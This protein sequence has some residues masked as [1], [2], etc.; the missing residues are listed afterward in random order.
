MQ[1]LH[2]CTSVGVLGLGRQTHHCTSLL[3]W[4]YLCMCS[5]TNVL[6]PSCA[7]DPG[8]GQGLASALHCGLYFNCSSRFAVFCRVVAVPTGC[9]LMAQHNAV[10]V[11]C[12]AGF[13]I[14]IIV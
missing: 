4:Q 13:G 1:L 2:A 10:E 14:L 7:C 3:L 8:H 5:C 6:K 12:K 11:Q 9:T